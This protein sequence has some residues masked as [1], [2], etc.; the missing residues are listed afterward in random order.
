M[1]GTDVKNLIR[2]DAVVSLYFQCENRQVLAQ[3]AVSCSQK[4]SAFDNDDNV[5]KTKDP[6]RTKG[7]LIVFR[8]FLNAPLSG[9]GKIGVARQA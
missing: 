4:A 6:Y 7:L 2:L 5:K 1:R 8:W 3:R 9:S